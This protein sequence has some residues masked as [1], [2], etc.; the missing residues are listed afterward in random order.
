MMQTMI[1][2]MERL[3]MRILMWTILESGDHCHNHKNNRTK[4]RNLDKI[5]TGTR[6]AKTVNAVTRKRKRH[7]VEGRI[8]TIL[9]LSGH[10]LIV[11]G[12]KMKVIRFLFFCWRSSK[13]RQ[14]EWV[15]E[16]RVTLTTIFFFTIFQAESEGKVGWGTSL[17][18]PSPP[19]KHAGSV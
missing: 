18:P 4:W 15:A 5:K 9:F 14:A 16:E 7:H 2:K 13:S 17:R 6:K 3:T 10:N 8:V 12:Q 19:L 11:S 1:M